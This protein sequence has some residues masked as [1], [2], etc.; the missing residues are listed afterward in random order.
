MC[1]LVILSKYDSTKNK[2]LLTESLG[3]RLLGIFTALSPFYVEQLHDKASALYKCPTIRCKSNLKRSTA[4]NKY[5]SNTNFK[6]FVLLVN[7]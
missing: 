7:T 4:P 3:Q 1:S 6:Q 5:I 2:M